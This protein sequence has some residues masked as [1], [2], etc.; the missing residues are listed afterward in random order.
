MIKK[1]PERREE[2]ECEQR[3]SHIRVMD[4]PDSDG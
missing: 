2:S 3:D 1:F 4:R